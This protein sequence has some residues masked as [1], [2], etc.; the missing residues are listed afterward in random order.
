MEDML[1][2]GEELKERKLL[3]K[4]L[5]KLMC[6]KKNSVFFT[7]TACFVLSPD[8][9]L[10]DESHVLLKVSRKNNMYSVDMKNIVPKE[11]LTCLVAKATLDESMLWHMRLGHVNFKIINKLVKE[12]LVRG[13]PVKG[14]GPKWLFDID[15]LTKLMNYVP[16]VWQSTNYL[17]ILIVMLER[18]DDGVKKRKLR[19]DNQERPKKIVLKIS[20]RMG[21]SISYCPVDNINYGS[22]NINIVSPTVTTAR[23]NGSQTEPDMFSLGD[24]ATLEA[25]HA[26]FFGDETEV[27]MS[28][29]TTTYP[30][31]STLNTRIHKDHSLDYVIGDVQYGVQTRRMTKT[32]NEQEFISAVYKGK[33]HEDLHICIFACFLSQVEP[34][35]SMRI[36]QY[37]THTDYAFWEVIMNGNAPAIASASTEGHIPPK[38]AEQQLARKN[39]LK[40]K[41]TLLLAILDEHLLK[42]HGIKDAKTLWEAIKT[43]FGGN[44]E[45]K[46][47]QKTIMKQQYENFTASRSEGLDKTYD[48]KIIQRKAVA[49]QWRKLWSINE[50]TRADYESGVAKPKIEDK[51]NFELKG[52]FLKELRSNTFSGS[53]HED[54][55]EHIEKVLEIVNLFHIPNITI[56]QVM[57]RAFP[58]SLT[59]ATS[60]WLKQTPSCRLQLGKI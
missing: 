1:P 40:A 16:V 35:K 41:S 37:L 52:Q 26:N 53:D 33:T 11:I 20:I 54:A 25:T 17:R 36:E 55:N 31:P 4:E 29:I 49:N 24:N 5:L 15:V 47:M 12:N 38:T 60:R 22:L 8:F 21:L 28:N 34:K 19:I 50:Q 10:A 14:D 39:E 48:R 6:D 7:D 18:M 32:S 3:V 27:D 30:V 45:S 46:K 2:L 56:D 42:F 43:R 57:L 59:G 9:K 23:S 51:D 44:K 58:M 13:L